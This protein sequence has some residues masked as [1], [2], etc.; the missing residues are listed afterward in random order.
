M[1]ESIDVELLSMLGSEDIEV[2]EMRIMIATE[3]WQHDDQ[4]SR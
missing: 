4:C 2:K 1:T 3:R